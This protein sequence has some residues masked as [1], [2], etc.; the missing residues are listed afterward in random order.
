[1]S[2]RTAAVSRKTKETAID[3]TLNLNGSGKAKIQ[4]GIGFF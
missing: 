1:M 4:T 2:K 3:V